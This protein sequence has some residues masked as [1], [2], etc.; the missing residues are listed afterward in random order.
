M[1]QGG[2][3]GSRGSGR[4]RVA[5]GVSAGWATVGMR[6][7]V[8][9][10]HG[11]HTT[12]SSVHPVSWLGMRVRVG[13]RVDRCVREGEV[14]CVLHVHHRRCQRAARLWVAWV[15]LAETQCNRSK[16]MEKGGNGD[17][18]RECFGSHKRELNAKR[19]PQKR[20]EPA[21]GKQYQKK[22]HHWH[23]PVGSLAFPGGCRVTWE[24][25]QNPMWRSCVSFIWNRLHR[26]L[27]VRGGMG[28]GFRGGF[29]SGWVD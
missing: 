3:F 7:R 21:W 6:V 22:H 14:L 28:M 8:D 13:L 15:A 12:R 5:M 2:M 23:R 9:R 18:D 1:Y 26:R 25:V 17:P 19:F 20:G 10:L 4:K 29:S 11:Y 16:T 27:K 24:V